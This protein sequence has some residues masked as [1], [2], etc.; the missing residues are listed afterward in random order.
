MTIQGVAWSSRGGRRNSASTAAS[1]PSIQILNTALTAR[2]SSRAGAG[3]GLLSLWS[4]S[5]A[6]EEALC[7]VLGVPSLRL[8]VGQ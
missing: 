5:E 2:S 1:A 8:K 6:L 3:W 4:R 7:L